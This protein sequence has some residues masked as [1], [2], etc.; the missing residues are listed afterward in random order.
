MNVIIVHGGA[1]T[2]RDLLERKEAV[3]KAVE[4]GYK[5]LEESG[6]A[7]DAAIKAT[8]I[9]EDSPYFNAGTGS[10]LNIEGEVEMDASIMTDSLECGAVA[11]I[12]N[13]KNPIL[14]A[15]FVMEKTDHIILS[16]EGAQKFAEIMGVRSYDP[17]TKKSKTLYNKLMRKIKAGQGT[18]YFPRLPNFIEYYNTDTVGAI[19]VDEEGKFAVTNS[20]AGVILKLPGRL[21]DTPVFGAGLYANELGAVSATG[22]GEG[23]IRLCLSKEAVDL[24]KRNSA[25]KSVSIAIRKAKRYNCRCGLIAIDRKG[26]VGWGHTADAMPSAYIKNGKLTYK[27][28]I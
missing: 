24:M 19:A 16:G 18:R 4:S 9:L 7:I 23:I 17:T 11:C 5:I 20:T 6:S 10:G 25:Q 26:R 21:G 8:V 2:K 3:I 28:W 15:K 27:D 22:H 14:I 12:K 13:V 1:G